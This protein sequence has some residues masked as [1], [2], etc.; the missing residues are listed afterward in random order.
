[1]PLVQAQKT[2]GNIDEVSLRAIAERWRLYFAQMPELEDMPQ[3]KIQAAQKIIADAEA[4]R[5][6]SIQGIIASR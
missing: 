6:A 4:H 1:M 2:R 3:E 5:Q